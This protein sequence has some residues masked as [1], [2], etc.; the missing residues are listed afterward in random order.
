MDLVG[1]TVPKEDVESFEKRHGQA[2]S[3]TEHKD[4][5]VLYYDKELLGKFDVEQ[6]GSWYT[7]PVKVQGAQAAADLVSEQLV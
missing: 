6:N 4:C 5:L 2:E 7:V 1:F 3:R